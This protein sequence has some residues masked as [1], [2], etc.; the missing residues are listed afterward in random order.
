MTVDKLLYKGGSIP[1]YAASMASTW[2]WAPALFVSSFMGY[3]YGLLGVAIFSIPN[4]F[5]IFL[6]GL[7]AYYVIKR[8]SDGVTFLDA[9]SNASKPQ[10]AL[11]F[12]VGSV[13]TICS[14]MVQL[15]GMH[16]LLVEWFDIS[17][18]TSASIISVISLIIVWYHG[19]KGSII[20]DYWKWIVTIL[21]GIILSVSV[22]VS[23]DVSVSAIKI[24]DPKDFDYLILFGITAT[25]GWW[26][27][28]F[29]DQ[30]FW[31][32]AYSSE[33][34]DIIKVFGWASVMFVF[35]PIFFGMVG[36]LA[37]TIGTVEGWNI[38]NALGTTWMGAVLG[39][40]IF[41]ALLSTLDSNLCAIQSLVET[42]FGWNGHVAMVILLIVATLIV[43]NVSMTIAG[44]F[45]LYGTIRA[46]VAFPTIM[47]AFNRF[48][49]KRLLIGTILSV[50]FGAGGYATAVYLGFSSP[51][52]F[53]A[54]AL[55]LPLI[56]YQ[57]K[58]KP[59]LLVE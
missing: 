18:F 54:L 7:F 1:V 9:L 22:F 42:R 52:I 29:A 27:A 23:P 55:C 58:S 26:C 10:R 14:T 2:V 30:T 25:I 15:L 34:K 16:L 45:L 6:F 28:P 12:A 36:M 53:T 3:Y 41:C 5:A 13:I 33:P 46:C 11:H 32:R 57:P 4:A 50:I 24:F 38:T 59:Q 47:I 17:Q 48:N 49:E 8:K 44:L 31:Q 35:I 51:W 43:S 37:A 19:I 40:A 39:V 56:G 21:C 20:S